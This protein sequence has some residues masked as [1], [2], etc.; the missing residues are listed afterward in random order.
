[1]SQKLF[2]D[3][4]AVLLDFRAYHHGLKGPQKP[5]TYCDN[6]SFAILSFTLLSLLLGRDPCGDRILRSCLQKGHATTPANYVHSILGPL[7]AQEPCK[8]PANFPPQ[9]AC[10]KPIKFINKLPQDAQG[11]EYRPRATRWSLQSSAD[12]CDAQSWTSAMLNVEV[13][14]RFSVERCSSHML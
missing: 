11:Q 13:F 10:E 12:I 9:I 14:L 2:C 5:K 6:S 3:P 8:I 1:M 7:W 4:V